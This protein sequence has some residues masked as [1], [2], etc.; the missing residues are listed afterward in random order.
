MPV[1]SK[2]I[3]IE[4]L[5]GAGKSTQIE[6]L[7]HY[8]K[9]AGIETKFV[10]FPRSHE[11]VFGELTAK[12]LRGD[13][14]DVR[15]V[16]PQLVALL[17]AEDRK[18]FAATINEWLA[19]GYFVLVDRYV[20]SNVAYQCAKLATPQEKKELREW[21]YMFEYEYNR[22]PRPDVSLYL[23]V[24]F[25]FTQKSLTGERSGDERG[26]L[27]GGE[28]I[29]EKDMS[30]QKAVKEEYENMVKTDKDIHSIRCYDEQLKM[31]PVA[32]IHQSIIEYIQQTIQ[33][34]RC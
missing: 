23:E 13:F 12:F 8:L 7:T 2:F 16:H 30:L 10:H 24:P 11:G 33:V 3:A 29:H 26:Y 31:K 14:G 17:F 18:A 20:L 6:L 15:Q 5:D 28:D 19:G 9:T 22:I 1:N 32:E 4:G 25:S 21:I 27:N 34:A